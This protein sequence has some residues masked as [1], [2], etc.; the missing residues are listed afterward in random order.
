MK[1]Q[2]LFGQ[3][4]SNSNKLNSKMSQNNL[5][6]G[7]VETQQHLHKQGNP[8]TAAPIISARVSS[9]SSKRSLDHRKQKKAFA[10]NKTENPAKKLQPS[11]SN[12]KR[13]KTEPLMRHDSNGRA[14]ASRSSQQY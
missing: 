9:Q 1:H 6:I 3:E 4:E 14:P 7:A 2:R 11:Q 10:T 13:I 8:S 5:K 12:Y